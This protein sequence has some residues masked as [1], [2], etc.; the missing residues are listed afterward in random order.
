MKRNIIANLKIMISRRSIWC[1]L[2]ILLVLSTANVILNSYNQIGECIDNVSAASVNYIMNWSGKFVTIVVYLSLVL[3]AIPYANANI[4]DR[5]RNSH[6]FI[7]CRTEKK[8]WYFSQLIVTMFGTFIVFL[9]P[10]LFNIALNEIIYAENGNYTIINE[11]GQY[12]ESYFMSITGADSWS[13]R[14]LLFRKLVYFYPQIYNLLY[15]LLFSFSLAVFAGF[16]YAIS[17][18]INKLS[19]IIYVLPLLAVLGAK[20]FDAE[21]YDKGIAITT[22]YL[23]YVY[24]SYCKPYANYYVFWTLCVVL[25]I[26]AVVLTIMKGKCDEL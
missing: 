5:K 20:T 7:L 9:L 24:V 2:W 13:K 22:D 3:L 19:V 23:P 12:L 14:G 17:L 11:Q 10:L 6:Y 16:L 1:V 21:L 4:L 8:S 26:W 18:Y 25:L 15:A